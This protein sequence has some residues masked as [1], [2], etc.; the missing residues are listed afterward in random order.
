MS[1]TT[2]TRTP[3]LPPAWFKHAFWRVHRVLCRLSGGRFLWTP[4]SK[5]GWGA[6]R[7][8][9]IGRKS[10]KERS[11]IVGYIED[12]ANLI[13]LA[14][15]GWDEGHPTWWLNLEAHPDAVV[16]LA[17]QG[18]RPMHARL[19]AGDERE[20]LWQRWLEIEPEIDTYAGLRSV[21]TPIVV[22]EP[23]DAT[24]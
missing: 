15:N 2:T 6:A 18:P 4:A 17:R 11:V 10:G 14:M 3:K 9:T 12:G 19:A 21:E 13:V 22:L 23:R 16:R 7:L 20:R 1:D 5:R 8:T 24:A